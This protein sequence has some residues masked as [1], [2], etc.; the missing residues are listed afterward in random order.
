MIQQLHSW[1]YTQELK[2]GTQTEI[3][4]LMYIAALFTTVKMQK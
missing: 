3:C 2:A 1:V 4:T